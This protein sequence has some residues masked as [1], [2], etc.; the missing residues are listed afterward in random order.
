[1]KLR[2]WF[3]TPFAGV[4]SNPDRK[5]K[6]NILASLFKNSTL[7]NQVFT[8]IFCTGSGAMLRLRVTLGAA[9]GKTTLPSLIAAYH[10][11]IRRNTTDILWEGST[12]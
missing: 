5:D 1:M 4:W 6:G 10:Q 9:T 8:G 12:L 3:A 7:Q 11:S 2:A